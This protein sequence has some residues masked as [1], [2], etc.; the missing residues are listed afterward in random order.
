MRPMAPSRGRL[1][2]VICFFD[3]EARREPALTGASFFV[4]LSSHGDKLYSMT[5]VRHA[6]TD[7]RVYWPSTWQGGGYAAHQGRNLATGRG[8]WRPV[9]DVGNEMDRQSSGF[10]RLATRSVGFWSIGRRRRSN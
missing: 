6:E 10:S 2:H 4:T 8:Y 7:C 9:L 3:I 5:G 1:R